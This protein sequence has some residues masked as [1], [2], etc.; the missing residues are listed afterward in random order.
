MV[1]EKSVHMVGMGVEIHCLI[2]GGRGG[3]TLPY[4]GEVE[5]HCLTRGEGG[6]RYTAL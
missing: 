6:W 1:K 2:G 5:I 4:E 3:D